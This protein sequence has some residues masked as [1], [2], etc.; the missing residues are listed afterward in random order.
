MHPQDEQNRS[1]TS[2]PLHLNPMDILRSVLPQE[3]LQ[4]YGFYFFNP[5]IYC[6]N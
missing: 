2:G 1:S 4:R 5:L 3:F 6:Q